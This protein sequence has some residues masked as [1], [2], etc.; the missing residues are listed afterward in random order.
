MTE[1]AACVP[2]IGPRE[3]RKRLFAGMAGLAV[4][5]GLALILISAGVGQAWRLVLFLP[6]WFG[7]LGVF[8]AREKT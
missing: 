5:V 4:G 7:A 3:R 1:G 2:N 8:Q 6:Y